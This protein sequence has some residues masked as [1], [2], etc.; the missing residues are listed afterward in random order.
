MVAIDENAPGNGDGESADVAPRVLEL[1]K[2]ARKDGRPLNICAPMV[3][4]RK[5][6]FRLLVRDYGV[7][8]AYTPMILAHEFIRSCIARDSD[9]TTC[10]LERQPTASDGRQHALIAQFAS[11][12][13]LEFARA[14]ELIAPRVDGVDLNCGCP[15]S[16]ALKDG[17]GC[18]LM[19]NPS[20]VAEMVRAA[21]GRL[22]SG[23]SVSVKIRIHKDLDQTVQWVKEVEAAGVTFI[24]VH[25]RTR[26]QRSST[27]PDYAAIRELK[28][29]VNVP[30]VAN[31]DAYT[32]TNVRKIAQL[33]G[34]DGVMAAR[35]MLENPA[36]FAGYAVTPTE[37]VRRF[38]EYAIRCPIP[39]PLVLH[40]IS[41]MT[42]RMEGMGKRERKRL[43][44]CR[45]LVDLVIY[46][47]EKWVVDDGKVEV[48]DV[49]C[50]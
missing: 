12:E 31:G 30:L 2:D 5:L 4:Y 33:T 7:D 41:E 32:S 10:P 22:S 21:R 45:D 42:A 18:S 28:K 11:S 13:P 25:G 6:P 40:H 46:V 26:S 38:L 8:I 48:D 14:A 49:D 3:R 34:A 15:Q 43:M 23:Q 1:F 29:H 35:G 20:L 36:L 16:W 19:S 50:R 17:I 39:L 47:E 9:F 27:A 37:A 44:E 24:T